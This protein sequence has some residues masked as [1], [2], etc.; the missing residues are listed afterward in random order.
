MFTSVHHWDEDS[1]GDWTLTI[2][3]QGNGD[4][5]TLFDWELNVYGTEL[6]TDRDGDGLTNYDEISIY[7]T[8]PDDIDTDDDQINDG[9][10]INTYGTNPLLIDSDNDGLEDGREILVNGTDPVSYTHLTLP[11]KRIV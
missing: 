7:G 11:T 5:G 8:D 2:E 9:D 6:N 3:D 1:F 10:E 4:T